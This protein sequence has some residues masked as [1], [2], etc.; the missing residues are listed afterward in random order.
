VVTLDAAEATMLLMW[1]SEGN[2]WLVPGF[3]YQQPEGWW[4]TVVS[5]VEG[6]IQL[7][8]PV[9]MEPYAVDP[10]VLDN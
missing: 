10:E 1:D 4:N 3:A 6:V 5:L 2:A 7:P 9:V 8:E